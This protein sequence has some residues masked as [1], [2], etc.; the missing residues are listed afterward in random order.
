[1]HEAETIIALRNIAFGFLMSLK[2]LISVAH[3]PTSSIL[4][5][6]AYFWIVYSHRLPGHLE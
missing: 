3:S 1:M 6:D 2:F 4:C 5:C